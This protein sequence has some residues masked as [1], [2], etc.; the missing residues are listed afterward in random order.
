MQRDHAGKVRPWFGNSTRW[1]IV[2]LDT[3]ADIA[4][5]VF[6]ESDWT[7]SEGLVIRDG[8]NYR[9]LGR[10]A[11]NAIA[12]VYLAR[13]SACKC[14][15]YYDRLANGSLRIEGENRIA[16][17][18]AEESEIRSNPAARYY[19]LDGVGRCLPYMVLLEQQT[20]EFGP[21]EAFCAER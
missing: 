20:R 11:E 14:K 13:T 8:R 10:V 15:A 9:L 5:L 6:L 16:I 7:K 3:V 18:S 21:I 4:N 12:G 1:Y 19:L 17:C 2:S